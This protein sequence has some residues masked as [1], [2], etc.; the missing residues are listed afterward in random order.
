MIKNLLKHSLR[1]L[2]K[3][4]GY[5]AINI[6]GLAIGIACSII[7]ALFIIHELSYDQYNENKDRM[8]RVILDGKIGE[9]EV[10]A[11][12]TAAVI[13]PTMAID[14]PEVEKF[15]R[16]NTWGEAIVKKEDV[17]YVIEDFAEV[18]STFFEIFSIPLLKGSS[19]TVLNEPNTMVLSESTAKKI[20]GNE[21]PI[22]KLL[23]VNTGQ[24][25]YRI[26]GVM[27]DF[28]EGN[29]FKC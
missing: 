5:V 22:N 14:F 20:F 8:Y 28:P 19:K 2:K 9:Q 21:D 6:L 26:T 24:E 18:D 1:A 11:S 3:Q 23:R 17:A 10:V 16:L 12:Y 7:I 29:T 25:P 13:G 4:K 15:C 27:A